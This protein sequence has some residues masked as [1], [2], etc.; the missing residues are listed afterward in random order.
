LSAACSSSDGDESGSDVPGFVG[1]VPGATPGIPTM[2][3][4]ADTPAAPGV[5]D[6]NAAPP[7][8]SQ[9]PAGT[10]SQ[11]TPPLAT[12]GAP[13]PAPGAAAPAAPVDGMQPP[14]TPPAAAPGGP[15]SFTSGVWTGLVVAEKVLDATTL[16]PANFDAHV[17]GEPFCLQGQVANDVPQSYTGVARMKFI[18]SQTAGGAPAAVTPQAN[19]LAFTFTRSSGSLIRI[20]LL[21]PPGV[22]LPANAD[23]SVPEGWCYAIPE[24]KGQ[25]FVPYTEFSTR[26]FDRTNLGA[27]YAREPIEA[28][29]FDAPGSD[30]RPIDYDFC[31]AG[32]ADGNDVSAAPAVPAGFLD[33]DITGTLRANFERALVEDAEGRK[34]IV[35]SNSWNENIAPNSQQLTYTNNSFTVSAAPQR[36]G[37]DGNVPLSFPSIYIGES[38]FIDGAQAISTRRFDNLPIQIPNIQSI[39]T[40]FAHNATNQD[41]NATYDVWFAAQPP[42]AEYGTATG[43]FL[44]VWTYKPGNRNAIGTMTRTATVGGQTWQVFVGNRSEG[45]ASTGADAA[46][47]V[48]S[49]VKQG[50][51]I[52]S[53]TFDLND[54]IRDAVN[55]NNLNG[56]FFLT[57]VFAGFEIWGGGQGLSVTNFTVDVQGNQ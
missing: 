23:G 20:N 38:G 49:Y 18:L 50:A 52:P 10:E 35:Q 2:P 6:P 40:T 53:Y 24:V 43:A 9:T 15:S 46:A 11:G 28:I 5:T 7:P 1:G 16:N 54:F 25:V 56:N 31:V 14:V 33:N 36:N 55:A 26:C 13:A 51:A 17:A 19:G 37:G 41:A 29:S 47:P 44:M 34:L 39:P 30:Q 42:T 27:V 57:D 21:A 45:G 12:P 48:I 32:I 3:G 4:A 8:V 22:Q